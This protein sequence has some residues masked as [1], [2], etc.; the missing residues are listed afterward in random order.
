MC[1][2]LS[3]C[4][5]RVLWTLRTDKPVFSSPC[6]SWTSTGLP[7]RIICEKHAT[8]HTAVCIGSHDGSLRCIRVSDGGLCWSRP[9]GAAVFSSPC[10]VKGGLATKRLPRLPKRRRV[11][12]SLPV[13]SPPTPTLT[14][15]LTPQYSVVCASIDG[16]LHAVD[17][18]TGAYCVTPQHVATFSIPRCT[19]HTTLETRE[20]T[21]LG[22][23]FSS[24]VG[25]S[26]Q[27]GHL[28]A[29]VHILWVGCRDECVHC[30]C[31]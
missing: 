18:T 6:S 25:C 11:A 23:V 19:Q 22:H 9:C 29:V 31:L 14:P 10:V 30:V 17:A 5:G 21:D 12:Q 26:V 13:R 3:L 27:V 16:Q 4:L 8:A 28:P 1:C 20:K 24:V 7:A 15:T 2:P